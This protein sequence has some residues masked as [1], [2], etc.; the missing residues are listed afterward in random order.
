VK[1][2]GQDLYIGWRDDATYGV[3]KI[4]LG[5]GA[6]DGGTWE[7]RIFDDGDADKYKQAI[8]MEITFETLTTNQTVTPK[9]KLNRGAWVTGTA[10]T[11]GATE[12]ELYINTIFKEIEVGFDIASSSNTFVK[13]TSVSFAYEPQ[14][15]EDEDA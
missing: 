5:D 6:V 8:K 14:S 1:S 11:S 13:I 9:Y 12:I 2:F 7:S 15:Q 3:D 4:A 10:A